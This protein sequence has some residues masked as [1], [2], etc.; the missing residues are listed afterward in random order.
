MENTRKY[1]KK[2]KWVSNPKVVTFGT[3]MDGFMMLPPFFSLDNPPSPFIFKS[4]AQNVQ[5]DFKFTPIP[6]I[7]GDSWYI[8]CRSKAR[9]KCRGRKCKKD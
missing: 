8:D 1:F 7:L 6:R 9:K 5:V 3:G 4:E 2:V